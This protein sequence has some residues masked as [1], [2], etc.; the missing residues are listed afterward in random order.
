MTRADYA[1][2]LLASSCMMESGSTTTTLSDAQKISAQKPFE[3]IDFQE[4][5]EMMKNFSLRAI[6][7]LEILHR[8]T[9][10]VREYYNLYVRLKMF[11]QP[12]LLEKYK[13]EA[14][15]ATM[16]VYL[17][18]QSLRKWILLQS[19]SDTRVEI[20]LPDLN[21]VADGESSLLQS[22]IVVT[23]LKTVPIPLTVAPANPARASP[24]GAGQRKSNT[25][26]LPVFSRTEWKSATA[27]VNI[28]QLIQNAADDGV[29]VPSISGQEICL[30]WHI[31]GKCKSDCRKRTTHV[32]LTNTT[33]DNLFAWCR[34][35]APMAATVF[36]EE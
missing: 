14:A 18:H 13:T 6:V 7:A 15:A 33:K 1:R 32:V 30:W 23:G 19:S 29:P 27:G 4:A 5:E 3:P 2:K 26:L 35:A 10:G 8:A 25:N 24:S 36:P 34:A 20:R 31:K 9:I 21:R 22:A 17:M 11:L 16:L 28:G 12:V